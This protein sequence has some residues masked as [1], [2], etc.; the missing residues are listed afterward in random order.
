MVP[1]KA[2]ILV[3]WSSFTNPDSGWPDGIVFLT[4]VANPNFIHAGIDAAVRLA[5]DALNAATAVPSA[6]NSTLVVGFC[7]AS[8]FAVSMFYC[9]NVPTSVIASPVP[10]FEIWRQATGSTTGATVMTAFLIAIGFFS[11]NASQQ[12]AARIVRPG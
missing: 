7:T 10:I 2:S 1:P 3:V 4:G 8:S 9:I 6:L 12:T 11:L 5:E